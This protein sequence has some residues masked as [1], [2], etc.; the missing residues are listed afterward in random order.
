MIGGEHNQRNGLWGIIIPSHPNEKM[1]VQTNNYTT[2]AS[3]AILYTSNNKYKRQQILYVTI[4]RPECTQ[5]SPTS[6][7]QEFGSMNVLIDDNRDNNYLEKQLQ[8]YTWTRQANVIIRREK[9]KSEL[10]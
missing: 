4:Q 3:H 10:V 5:Q 6:Y 2:V 1:S 7:I 9:T 8:E